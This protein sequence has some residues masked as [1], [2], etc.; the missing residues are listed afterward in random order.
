M[1]QEKGIV[2]LNKFLS[3]E[4][5]VRLKDEI[6]R[7]SKEFIINGNSKGSIWI[8]NNQ[9]EVSNPIV[10]I[11][12]VNLLDIAFEIYKKLKE[13]TSTS[14]TLTCLRIM[15]ERKNVYPVNWHTDSAKNN[16]RG[17]LYLSGGEKNNGNLSYVEGSHKIDHKKDETHNIDLSKLNLE[18]KIYTCDS[19]PGDLVLIDI[20]GFH[21]KNIVQNERKIIFFEFQHQEDTQKTKTK[22]IFDNSKITEE[23]LKEPNFLF[24]KSDQAK[25]IEPVY[26]DYLIPHTPLKVF[27]YYFF[28]FFKI[29]LKKIFNKFNL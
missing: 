21:K 17:L 9:F 4:K 19:K 14:Y 6:N 28:S 26:Y 1:L 29:Q 15:G 22:I 7:I 13:I 24:Y 5:L 27:R 20:N 10:N 23:M 3:D 12:S 11:E 8:N 2:H 16:I 25:L 18:T